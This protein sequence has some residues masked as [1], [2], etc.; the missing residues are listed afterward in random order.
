ML[1]CTAKYPAKVKLSETVPSPMQALRMAQWNFLEL[2]PKDCLTKPVV[3]GRAGARFH[4]IMDPPLIRTILN[5]RVADFP[6]GDL[7]VDLFR[8]VAIDNIVSSHDRTWEKLRPPMARAVHISALEKYSKDFSAAAERTSGQISAA[9]NG[10]LDVEPLM[11]SATFDLIAK[12]AMADANPLIM[13]TVKRALAAFIEEIARFSPL[14]FIAAPG[15]MPR[16]GRS[17]QSPTIA[18]GRR[19]IDTAI[20]QRKRDGPNPQPD[21][22]DQLLA[23]QAKDPDGYITDAQIRDN[24][25]VM[26]IAGH[27]TTARTLSWALYLSAFDQDVQK[28]AREQAQRVLQGRAATAKDVKSMPLIGNIIRETMR[29]YPSFPLLVRKSLTDDTIGGVRFRKGDQILI[30]LYALH[31]HHSLWKDPDRFDPVRFDG[32][33]KISKYAFIPF[34]AGPRICI[35]ASFAQLQAQIM[36]ATLLSRHRF[37]VIEGRTPKPGLSFSLISKNGIHLAAAPV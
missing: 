18:Y 36:L 27:D 32:S 35:G 5:A 31:R 7:V 10:P 12:L 21:I 3:S 26:L 1:D 13:Q 19:L 14:D 30:P 20:K 15:W 8:S 9:E 33:G 37:E 29:L 6:K 17:G 24:L 22:L 23:A 4:M 34:G 2:L 28:A 11:A 25:A 16:L